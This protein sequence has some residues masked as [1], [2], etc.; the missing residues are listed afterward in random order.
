MTPKILEAKTVLVKNSSVYI[1]QIWESMILE[2]LRCSQYGLLSNAISVQKIEPDIM[3]HCQEHRHEIHI[4]IDTT[5]HGNREAA[6]A[7]FG[8]IA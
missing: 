1:D 7:S 6:L 4:V 2:T 5:T 8:P 3:R